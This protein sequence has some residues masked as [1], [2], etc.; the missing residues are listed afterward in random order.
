MKV[1]NILDV[2][3][4]KASLQELSKAETTKEAEFIKP[5]MTNSYD[6]IIEFY[7]RKDKF[8]KY[9]MYNKDGNLTLVGKAKR[10]TDL[11]NNGLNKNATIGDYFKT[12]F[13]KYIESIKTLIK[14]IDNFHKENPNYITIG[15]KN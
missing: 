5:I 13:K 9:P 7:K 15:P 10:L 11:E 4:A 6:E 14:E 12:M 2:K 8:E 1:K 3:Y